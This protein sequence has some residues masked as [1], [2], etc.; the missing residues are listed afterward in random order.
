MFTCSPIVHF[1]TECRKIIIHIHTE[2][3]NMVL[4]LYI[5]VSYY[6]MYSV[7]SIAKVTNH[8]T[9]RHQ[10]KIDFSYEKGTLGS[11]GVIQI[12]V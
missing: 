3:K 10:N 8:A 5:V 4:S 9:H 6:N 2:Q 7:L 1:F 12:I 11:E